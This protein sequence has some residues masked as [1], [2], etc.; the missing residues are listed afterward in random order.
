MINQGLS[1][2]LTHSLF[3]EAYA[4]RVTNRR[5]SLVL[6]VA[7]AEVAVKRCATI[8]APRAAWLLEE[9]PSPPIAQMITDFLPSLLADSPA[10]RFPNRPSS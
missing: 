1:E 9:L 10:A 6:A 2:P 3:R 4:Q 8:L 7:A 5:S